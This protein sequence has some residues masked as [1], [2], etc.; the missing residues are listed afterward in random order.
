MHT[1]THACTHTHTHTHTHTQTHTSHHKPPT[2][3]PRD[4]NTPNFDDTPSPTTYL[5]QLHKKLEKDQDRL[6]SQPSTPS[7]KPELSDQTSRLS[8]DTSSELSTTET[9][10]SPPPFQYQERQSPLFKPYYSPATQQILLS[11]GRRNATPTEKEGGVM[12]SLNNINTQLGVLLSRLN[13]PPPG[14]LH[15]TGGLLDHELLSRNTALE[16][17]NR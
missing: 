5:A 14:G 1:R 2:T 3:P 16:T 10:A 8:S 9:E 15:S 17:S 7:P 4:L 11:G 12:A 13:Q 6:T